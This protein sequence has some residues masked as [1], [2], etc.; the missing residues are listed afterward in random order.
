[1][2][3]FQCNS[4]GK[5]NTTQNG[6]MLRYDCSPKILN[7]ITT[8]QYQNQKKHFSLTQVGYGFQ[9]YCLRR[10]MQLQ[11]MIKRFLS[12]LFVITFVLALALVFQSRFCARF[13]MFF[14]WISFDRCTAEI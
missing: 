13:S 10:L 7:Q 5:K 8:K 4:F 2:N 9:K 6:V 12:F 3:E 11:I 14:C 1:M